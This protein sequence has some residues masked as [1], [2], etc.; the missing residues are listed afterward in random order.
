MPHPFPGSPTTDSK[1][2]AGAQHSFFPRTSPSPSHS[3]TGRAIKFNTT[4]YSPVKKCMKKS[5][6][7]SSRVSF[8]PSVGEDD[9]VNDNNVPGP[10]TINRGEGSGLEEIHLLLQHPLIMLDPS[11]HHPMNL[12]RQWMLIVEV[13]V[14]NLVNNRLRRSQKR[15]VLLPTVKSK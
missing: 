6:K 12:Q 11:H 2:I 4:G 8:S 1:A 9:A 5:E 7:Q 10:P 13:E 15:N 14:F 3:T